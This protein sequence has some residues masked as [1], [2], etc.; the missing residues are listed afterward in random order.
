[1]TNQNSTAPERYT[2]ESLIE[3]YGIK[4]AAYYERLKFLGIKAKKD[5]QNKAYLD[6]EQVALLDELHEHIVSTGKMEGFSGGGQLA[7]A[8]K[9]GQ[10]GVVEVQI[11]ETQPDYEN[12]GSGE[13]DRLVRRAAEIKAQSLVTPQLVLLN[14]ASQMTENDLP[15]DLKQKVEEVRGAANPKQQPAQLASNLLAQ[16]RASRGGS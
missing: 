7:I 10:I 8:S 6:A 15:E 3:K 12:V 1:M 13:L 11:P 4:T 14:L 9:S 2:P 16:Y 5:S